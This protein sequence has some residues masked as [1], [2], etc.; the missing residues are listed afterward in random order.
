MCINNT[1]RKECSVIQTIQLSEHPPVPM[2][3]DKKH[4]TV[5]QQDVFCCSHGKSTCTFMI[6]IVLGH[7][8][9]G[10]SY[11]SKNMVG[12]SVFSFS[13]IF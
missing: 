11:M 1:V 5:L 12:W 6:I 13:S 3:S 2:H 8:E 4:P 7:T 10:F 9:K